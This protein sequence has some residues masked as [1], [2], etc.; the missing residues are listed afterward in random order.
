MAVWLFLAHA[1]GTVIYYRWRWLNPHVSSICIHQLRNSLW[2]TSLSGHS[3]SLEL[4][5]KCIGAAPQG[6]KLNFP[7]HL[8][9]NATL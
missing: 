9:I 8:L 6:Q 2:N 1:F 5:D 3:A 7:K 4:R